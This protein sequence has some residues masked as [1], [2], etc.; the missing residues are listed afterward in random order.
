MRRQHECAAQAFHHETTSTADH[1]RTAVEV[2]ARA[3]TQHPMQQQQQQQQ[4]QQHKH[5]AASTAPQALRRKNS[6]RAEPARATV[7]NDVGTLLDIAVGAA[8]EVVEVA[9]E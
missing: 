2:Q 8:V 4:Q 5:C 3:L 6:T 1:A 7:G 9:A